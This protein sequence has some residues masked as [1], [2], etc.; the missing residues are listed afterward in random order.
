MH[1]AGIAVEHGRNIEELDRR[2]VDFAFAGVGELLHKVA[3]PEAFGID[4]SGT[5]RG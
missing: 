5:F 4:R 3:Q 1:G 2:I